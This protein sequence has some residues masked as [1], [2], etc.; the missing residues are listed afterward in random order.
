[1]VVRI[2][3]IN[4]LVLA[5]YSIGFYLIQHTYS[6]A[7][8]FFFFM[9]MAFSVGLHIAACLIAAFVFHLLDF[10]TFQM[11]FLLSAFAVA[12][13]GFS[14]CSRGEYTRGLEF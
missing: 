9:A 14:F 11:G 3:G 1:M 4:L 12:L 2:A 10:R 6:E 5:V 8:A 7:G 13:L